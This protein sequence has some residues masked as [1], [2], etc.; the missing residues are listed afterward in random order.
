MTFQ[1]QGAEALVRLFTSSR[2]AEKQQASAF[3]NLTS[4][5]LDLLQTALNSLDDMADYK[6][7][8]AAVPSI[9]ANWGSN[10]QTLGD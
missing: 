2:N 5:R 3:V 10:L 4:R 7:L 6:S 9:R 1:K 8:K